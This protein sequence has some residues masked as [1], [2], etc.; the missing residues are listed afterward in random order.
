MKIL[1]QAQIK[2]ADAYT[3]AHEPIS[4]ADLME[5]AALAFTGKLLLFA[6]M[7]NI[8]TVD[9]YCGPGNNGGDGLAVARLLA[10]KGFAIRVFILPSVSYSV[11]FRHNLKRLEEMKL[12]S[13][14]IHNP[15]EPH[16]LLPAPAKGGLIVDA[17]FGTGLNKPL[18]GAAAEWVSH[19][20]K[21]SCIIVAI[22][23]PSGLPA[24]GP[25]ETG[26]AVVHATYT[27]TFQQPKLSLLFADHAVAVG[28]FEVL[29][30]GLNAEY[31]QS[32]QTTFTYVTANF[33]AGL[34][35]PRPKFSHKG[36][37]GH[38]LLV[39]GSLGKIGAALL[40]TKACLRSGAGLLTV[41]VPACGY[42]ILQSG[43][44]EAMVVPDAENNYVADSIHLDGFQAVG[45][46]PGLG[47]EKQTQNI[48]KLLI[49]QSAGPMVLDAD[50]LNILA[51]NKTWISFLPA[52]SI[53]TPHPKEFERLT[54]KKG[55]AFDRMGWQLEFSVKHRVYIVL[56]G[57]HTSI[58]TPEGQVFFNSTGNPGMAK[59]GSGDVLTGLLTGL[60]AQDYDPGDAAVLGVFLHGLAG[61]IAA[62]HL[63]MEAMT[64]GDIVS[65]FGEAFLRVRDAL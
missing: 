55:S 31:I 37:F 43:A 16:A 61:D 44:P 1:S 15:A 12:A 51:E 27:L 56:K 5:R 62:Q 8:R 17:L 30:I 29:D 33:A 32:V 19:I 23:L 22:D 25:L 28:Q 7:Q 24:D 42:S 14:V 52:G 58:S 20:N 9:V 48:L 34:L 39:A 45:A 35:M 6:F 63:S 40:A 50:A 4:S 13:V 36:T 26:A 41:H 2:E 38:A 57:A 53:L 21:Q 54:G 18:H 47:M 46:G 10:G 64:A 3:I 49:Q 60:L 11:D 59:G 65:G